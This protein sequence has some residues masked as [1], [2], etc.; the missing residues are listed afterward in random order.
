MLEHAAPVIYDF[1]TGFQRDPFGTAEESELHKSLFSALYRQFDQ[2]AIKFQMEKAQLD[3]AY[4]PDR[5]SVRLNPV[6]TAYPSAEKFS[7]AVLGG[8]GKG[9][10]E[11][12]QT[13]WQQPVVVAINLH[14]CADA[15][16]AGKYLRKLDK[17]RKK[18]EAYRAGLENREDFAGLSLLLVAGD[19]PENAGEE[20][21]AELERGVQTWIVAADGLFSYSG[22]S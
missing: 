4:Y 22:K 20:I 8:D 19:A 15:D 6:R 13:Y 18:M 16:L 3:I 7:V 5:D 10:E 17:D 9:G 14:H 1:L 2:L 21:E 11:R 12:F